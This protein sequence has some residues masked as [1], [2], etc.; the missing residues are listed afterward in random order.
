LDLQAW[1]IDVWFACNLIY[2]TLVCSSVRACV[3]GCSRVCNVH[4]N[5]NI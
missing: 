4:Y 5:E 3:R 1:Y 2:I